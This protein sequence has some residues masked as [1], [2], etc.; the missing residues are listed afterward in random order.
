MQLQ[1]KK[2]MDTIA[3]AEASAAVN[4]AQ[5]ALVSKIDGGVIAPKR[6]KEEVKTKRYAL[7]WREAGVGG[8]NTSME[9]QEAVVRYA[10]E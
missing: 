9:S 2:V 6:Q 3:A 5:G 1:Q 10:L 4:V 8:R 7:E